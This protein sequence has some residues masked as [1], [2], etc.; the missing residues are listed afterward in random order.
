MSKEK[1][2]HIYKRLAMIKVFADNPNYDGEPMAILC[3]YCA[4]GAYIPFDYG[5]RT[6]MQKQLSRLR[7]LS[8]I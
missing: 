1:H 8:K 6:V 3:R 2:E 4:C 7:G 5:E